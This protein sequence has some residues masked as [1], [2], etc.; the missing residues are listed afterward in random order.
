MST[1]SRN[2]SQ[3]QG[4]I[5]VLLIDDSQIVLD[6]LAFN[7]MFRD[8][9]EVCGK[10]QT[11]NEALSLVKSIVS[12]VILLDISLQE[13]SDGID[14]L[15]N[16]HAEYPKIKV[17]IFSQKKDVNSIVSTISNGARAFL[18]KDSGSDEIIQTICD[19]V[20]GNGIF[21]G[22]TIPESTLKQCFSGKPETKNFASYNLS[23][24]ELSILSWLAKGYISKEIAELEH[25]Q[26]STIETHKE[27]IKNKLGFKSIIEVV[28]FA[29]Q[30]KLIPI[31]Q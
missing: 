17:I 7:L 5:K 13:E 20:K 19:V 26:I 30:N 9:I 4:K 28:V 10:A 2:L 6:G 22:E 3:P 24:R 14:L 15:I 8:D 12:D 27:N 31:T 29:V 18:S 25:L 11:A 21:L 16:I 1:S 23:E